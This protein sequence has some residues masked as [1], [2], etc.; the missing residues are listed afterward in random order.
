[1]QVLA[2]QYGLTMNSLAP[3]LFAV[4]LAASLGLKSICPELQ[5]SQQ[6]LTNLRSSNDKLLRLLS[7]A[8]TKIGC[9]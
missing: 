6:E 4:S 1:M 8:Q 3:S 5:S 2:D 7:D 9:Q